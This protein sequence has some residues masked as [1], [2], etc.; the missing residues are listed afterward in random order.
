MAVDDFNS[1]DLEPES[2]DEPEP[3]KKR[4]LASLESMAKSSLEDRKISKLL[5][6]KRVLNCNTPTSQALLDLH[7]QRFEFFRKKA[8]NVQ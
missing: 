2:D 1:S 4:G 3:V 8:L 5:D 6:R 7:S